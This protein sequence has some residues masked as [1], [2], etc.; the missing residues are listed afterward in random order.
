MEWWSGR[1]RIRASELTVQRFNGSTVQRLTHDTK[2]LSRHL[3]SAL[4]KLR[5]PR[6]GFQNEFPP[7]D[8]RRDALVRAATVVLRRHLFAHRSY[9]HVVEVAGRDAAGGQP[10][11]SADFHGDIPDQLH[12]TVRTD[13]K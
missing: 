4:E 1:K 8:R 13:R 12:P 6:N 2:T 7:L 3:Q 5:R 10:F 11:H 9:R